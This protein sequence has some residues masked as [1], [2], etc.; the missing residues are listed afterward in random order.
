MT[1][2]GKDERG[3]GDEEGRKGRGRKAR[4]ADRWRNDRK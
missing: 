3:R 4:R 2:E 1:A